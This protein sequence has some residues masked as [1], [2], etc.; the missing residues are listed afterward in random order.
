MDRESERE[1]DTKETTACWS[2]RKDVDSR[3][4]RDEHIQSYSNMFGT[5]T[6]ELP[7]NL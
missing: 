1:A 3:Q 4:A 6:M 5:R 2:G 7:I